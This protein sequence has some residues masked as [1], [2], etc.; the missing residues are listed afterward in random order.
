MLSEAHRQRLIAVRCWE[1]YDLITRTFTVQPE[2]TSEFPDL[3][4]QALIT[5]ALS[6]RTQIGQNRF[7]Q[8][9]EEYGFQEHELIVETYSYL[10]LN[11]ALEIVIR[12]D[13]LPHHQHDYRKHR[14]Q[15][16]PHHLHD[17]KGRIQSFTGRVEDFV[18]EIITRQLA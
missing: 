16:F 9:V 6:L 13:S 14:L 12:A 10:L 4:E 15:H 8:I 11:Q 18:A 3:A 5:G 1:I 17:E 2:F 7:L